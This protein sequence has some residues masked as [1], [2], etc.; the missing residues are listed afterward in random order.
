MGDKSHPNS[1]DIDSYLQELMAE[2]KSL[3]Y[4]P[5][6]GAVLHDMDVEEKEYNLVHHSEKLAVAFAL[7]NTPDGVPIRIM[8]NLRVCDDCHVAMKYISVVKNREIIVRDSS[9]LIT[10]YLSERDAELMARL[11]RLW[12]SEELYAQ[13]HRLSPAHDTN[14]SLLK[15]FISIYA[16]KSAAQ[17]EID[18]V[19]WSILL[20]CAVLLKQKLILL[21]GL[22]RESTNLFPFP[23]EKVGEIR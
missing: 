20:N 9:R 19:A 22:N 6:I 8:K 5:D 1:E 21:P 12:K 2:L 23:V 13:V 10:W 15:S 3:G 17:A 11:G 7:M 4:A 16:N 18:S 14:D